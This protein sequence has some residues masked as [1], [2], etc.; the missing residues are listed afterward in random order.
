MA[1]NLTTKC[2]VCN[3]SQRGIFR[4]E[5]SRSFEREEK[6]EG[7]R[8]SVKVFLFFVQLTQQNTIQEKVHL[9]RK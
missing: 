2:E 8:G 7:E 3:K 9:K 6:E 1:A 4:V 5:A